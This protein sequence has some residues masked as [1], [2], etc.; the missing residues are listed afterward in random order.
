MVL[1]N[2]VVSVALTVD[3]EVAVRE[4]VPLHTTL[5][6]HH[7]T[8]STHVGM[9]EKG[10]GNARKAADVHFMG[11]QTSG[12]TDRVVVG[13]PH[14]RKDYTPGNLDATETAS[15]F[16]MVWLDHAVDLRVPRTGGRFIA[17]HK[18]EHVSKK[19]GGELGAII[20]D[21]CGRTSPQVL[22]MLPP[23]YTAGAGAR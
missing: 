23:L 1:P 15:I 9:T 14:D 3:S 22:A 11:S 13:K 6:T 2:Q 12:M 8:L 4:L 7:N 18:L 21:E 20:G 17:A 10:K 5:S 19:Y 16:A